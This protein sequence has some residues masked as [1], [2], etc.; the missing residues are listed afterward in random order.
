MSYLL[1][2]L[3]TRLMRGVTDGFALGR[4]IGGFLLT[5]LMRGVTPL[6]RASARP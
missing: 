2:F 6:R 3:L 1:Q 5:R 4:Q